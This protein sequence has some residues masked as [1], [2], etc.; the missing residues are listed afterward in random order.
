MGLDIRLY[1][2]RCP[3]WDCW[4]K[5]HPVPPL[6]GLSRTMELAL[7]S[8]SRDMSCPE[9]SILRLPLVAYPNSGSD[10]QIPLSTHPWVAT[11]PLILLLRPRPSPSLTQN[12]AAYRSDLLLPVSDSLEEGTNI[13]ND[14]W[15]DADLA[16]SICRI[17]KT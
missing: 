17:R 6:C 16:Y 9:P 11:E 12:H 8:Q 3:S 13:K 14:I 10:I 4:D 7:M 1:M 5:V 2:M 15:S